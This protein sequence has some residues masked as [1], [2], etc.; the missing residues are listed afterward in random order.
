MI[1]L[2]DG[3]IV[4]SDGTVDAPTRRATDL[5]PDTPWWYKILLEKAHAIW[6][7]LYGVAGVAA[8]VYAS[9]P[10]QINEWIKSVVPSTWWP[11]LVAAFL[12]VTAIRKTLKY[13]AQQP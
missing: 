6:A 11:H 12:A 4:K 10:D 9:N 7:F 5:P 2:Y 3:A 1:E 8:E 13:R